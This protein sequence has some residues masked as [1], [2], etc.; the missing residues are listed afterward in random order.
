MQIDKDIS[1]RISI[2]RIVM[3]FGIVILHLPPHQPLAE[4][5]QDFFS[6]V[7]AFF[8]YGVFRA[9]VPVLTAVSGYLVF[10]F[11]LAQ[12]PRL[13][14][15]KKSKTIL[16][17]LLLWNIPLAAAIF[18]AQMYHL[19]D[20]P[21]S[22]QLYPFSLDAWLDGLLGLY[23]QPVNYP[24]NFLRD[25][26][27]V[28]LLSPLLLLLLRVNF[29]LT[30]ACLAAV[31]YWNLDGMLVI[32]NSMLISFATGAMVA[33]Y[34]VDPRKLDR[35]AWML[36]TL[37]IG[38]CIYLV[39]FKVEN[40]EGLRMLAPFLIW[41]ILGK[42]AGSALGSHLVRYSKYSFIL[43]MSHAPVILILWYL[44]GKPEHGENSYLLY[45]L[46][47]SPLSLIIAILMHKVMTKFSPRL[48][49]LML[50]ER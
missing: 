42:L 28:C 17:P 23:T 33:W 9:S 18:I 4:V 27:A 39:L 50:G 19:S 44:F 47:A 3:I 12:Q 32:R 30:V 41:P 10:K 38:F 46:T 36:F 22:A 29:I 24:L 20:H 13:L 7:R 25:L 49:G 34:G 8:S 45:W 21:F 35:F 6:Y 14:L 5:G 16:L 48:K 43:F 11:A 31:Y 2:A 26:Y 40:R 1:Q 15:K 37:F